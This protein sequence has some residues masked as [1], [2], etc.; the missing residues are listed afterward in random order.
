ME[1]RNALLTQ[2]IEVQGEKLNPRSLIEAARSYEMRKLYD[3]L[4]QSFVRRL[5]NDFRWFK[6]YTYE[7]G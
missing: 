4:C 3:D 1:I 7:T 6:L 5:E 2:M